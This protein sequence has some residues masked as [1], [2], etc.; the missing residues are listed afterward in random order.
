[1]RG[2]RGLLRAG[3]FLVGFA[4]RG[5]PARIRDE[6]YREWAAELPAILADP[7]LGPGWRR[8]ARMLGYALGT[9][10]ATAVRSGQASYRGAHRGSDLPTAVKT[11]R[12][13]LVVPVALACLLAV[14]SLPLLLIY[15]VSWGTGLALWPAAGLALMLTVIVPLAVRFLPRWAFGLST[16]LWGSWLAYLLAASPSWWPAGA[17]VLARIGAFGVSILGARYPLDL[18]TAFIK[19][20]Q[21][22]PGKD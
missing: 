16:V 6:Q 15:L 19:R 10:R 17:P 5:L 1:M 11:R 18:I 9:I 2:E 13:V 4:A 14:L 7:G 12:L 8:A 20:H 22:H 3:E 21:L